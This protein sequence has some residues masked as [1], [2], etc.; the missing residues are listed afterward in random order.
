MT[1][2]ND[3]PGAPGR[4]APALLPTL[5]D[6]LRDDAPG[7]ASETSSDHAVS[8]AQLREIIQRDLA[9]LL[10][11][12]SAE[13][14]ID[15]RRYPEAA[16]STLNY[17]VP[18]LAGKD[19]SQRRWHDIERIVRRAI[20]DY[21]PRLLPGSVSVRPLVAERL[22]GSGHSLAFEI[23]ALIDARPYPLALLVQS[24]VDLETSRL[25]VFDA[26]RPSAPPR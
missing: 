15:R 20:A 9:L 13:G 2:T 19:M 6:R 16:R 26:A 21:E 22:G 11:T 23:H 3:R 24:A 8:P 1:W 12:T 5:F 4:R 18:P 17:G 14:L 7:C 10:N 25:R